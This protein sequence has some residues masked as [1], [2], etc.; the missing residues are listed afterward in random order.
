MLATPATIGSVPSNVV[1]SRKL[2]APD[3]PAGIVA[4]K[5]TV[6]PKIAGLEEVDMS[7]DVTGQDEFAFAV[8]PARACGSFAA[9]L[10]VLDGVIA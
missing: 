8:D 3:A 10:Y 4:V 1:P 7:V 2:T 5:V 9:A 6:L